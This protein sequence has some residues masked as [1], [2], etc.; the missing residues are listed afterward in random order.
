MAGK[1]ISLAEVARRLEI[2]P[3]TALR[4]LTEHGI[5]PAQ[6]RGGLHSLHRRYEPQIVKVMRRW[7]TDERAAR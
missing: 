4:L 5:R 1:L 3:Q 2:D 6:V 7:L